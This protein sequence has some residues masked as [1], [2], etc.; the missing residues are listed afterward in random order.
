MESSVPAN[1]ED[2]SSDCE[3]KKNVKC[4]FKLEYQAIARD[5]DSKVFSTSN[6]DVEDVKPKTKMEYNVIVKKEEPGSPMRVDDEETKPKIK[7]EY[8]ASVKKEEPM[9]NVLDDEVTFHSDDGLTPTGIFYKDVKPNIKLE[10]GRVAVKE[11]TGRKRFD[12]RSI[13]TDLDG[14]VTIDTDK[15][16]ES[17]TFEKDV[18]F[19][20]K[21]KHA[22]KIKKEEPDDILHNAPVASVSTAIQTDNILAP[23][24]EC[25]TIS[26]SIAMQSEETISAPLPPVSITTNPTGDDAI[27]V[28]VNT[29]QDDSAVDD[30]ADV[31]ETRS[32]TDE[33]SSQDSFIVRVI[34]TRKSKGSTA[35]RVTEERLSGM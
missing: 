26:A 17:G 20:I 27:S 15:M 4:K 32:S 23:L 24:D 12:L 19:K 16:A 31:D 3:E 14:E 29:D 1:Q 28:S 7:L 5:K 6:E 33:N 13:K 25:L 11:E 2:I 21:L 8:G 34:P 35:K 30:F 22:G 9:M 10:Y 18:K